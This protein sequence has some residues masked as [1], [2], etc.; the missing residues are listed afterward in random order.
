MFRILFYR[1]FKTYHFRSP[2]LN[3]TEPIPL[4]PYNQSL[5]I[6]PPSK[7]NSSTPSVVDYRANRASV[8]Y[9]LDLS[10]VSNL[11]TPGSAGRIRRQKRLDTTGLGERE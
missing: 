7:S 10:G 4:P 5:D 2:S 6:S 1:N 3:N 9:Q 8:S 11:S